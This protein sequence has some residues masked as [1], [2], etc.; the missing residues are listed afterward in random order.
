MRILLQLFVLLCG[1]ALLVGDVYAK[2][3]VL[4]LHADEV[5]YA[6]DV[7]AKLTATNEFDEIA[8]FDIR[9]GNIPALTLLQ[10]YDAVMVWS[11][12]VPSN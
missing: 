1:W 9:N 10:S 12:Y 2:P 6:M 7:K 11:N 4:L 3:K 5:S 8:N